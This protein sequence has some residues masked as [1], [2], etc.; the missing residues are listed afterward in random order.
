MESFSGPLSKPT[1]G[2]RET[3]GRYRRG[4]VTVGFDNGCEG[5]IRTDGVFR[6]QVMSLSRYQLRSTSQLRSILLINRVRPYSH[7]RFCEP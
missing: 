4:G 2:H 5:Q 7:I 6:R 3:D 1:G